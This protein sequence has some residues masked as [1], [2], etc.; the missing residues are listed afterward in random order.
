MEHHLAGVGG[1][2]L[3]QQPFGPAELYQLP[4]AGHHPTLEVDL[5]VTDPEDPA[6]RC[7]AGCPPQHRPNTGRGL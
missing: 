4:V 7:D 5:D 6:S 3:E 1:E 2:V